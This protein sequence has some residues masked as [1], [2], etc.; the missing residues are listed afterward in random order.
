MYEL[1]RTLTYRKVRIWVAGIDEVFEGVIQD[2]NMQIVELDD[3]RH[4]AVDKIA[5]VEEI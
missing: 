5:V 1:F 2:V 3:D 4:I